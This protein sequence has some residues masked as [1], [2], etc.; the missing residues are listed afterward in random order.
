M[1]AAVECSTQKATYQEEFDDVSLAITTMVLVVT[2][3]LETYPSKDLDVKNF[4]T[5][6]CLSYLNPL[7]P[8]QEA[9]EQL[10]TTPPPS[11]Q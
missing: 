7:I 9:V 11:A 4:T 10:S 6:I 5:T 3:F 8:S 2:N 1:R